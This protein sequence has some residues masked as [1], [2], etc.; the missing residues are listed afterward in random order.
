MALSSE[1]R[2]LFNQVVLIITSGSLNGMRHV[3]EHA[4]EALLGRGEDC[5]VRL[6][7]SRG[8]E[9]VSRHHCRLVLAPPEATLQDLGSKNG[10]LLNGVELRGRPRPTPLQDGD[11]ISVGRTT[12]RVE[13]WRSLARTFDTLT[14]DGQGSTPSLGMPALPGSMA[15]VELS[16][17]LIDKPLGRGVAGEVFLAQ[18]QASGRLVAIKTLHEQ[19][20][21]ALGLRSFVREIENLTALKHRHIVQLLAVGLRGQSP[22]LVLEY[23]NRGSL[24]SYSA[25]CGGYVPLGEAVRYLIQV[26]DGLEFAHS[27]QTESHGSG[28]RVVQS[29]GFVHRDLK[30]GNILLHEENGALIAKI[31]DFGLGK[32]AGAEGFTATGSVSGTPTYMPRQ[33]VLDYKYAQPE[34]DVWAATACFFR[35]VT[36]AYPKPLS[37]GTDPWMTA[38]TV[39][40]T[41]IRELRD[42]VPPPLAEVIDEALV[43]TP[44]IRI[45][46]AAELKRRLFDALRRIKSGEG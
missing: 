46:T 1:Q 33:Q 3:F 19:A 6:P 14:G 44:G 27:Q 25:E 38:L 4:A 26:L 23:C 12:L 37:H 28:G 9:G 15:L 17:Y 34:V 42:N 2:T 36:G 18:E 31:A 8:Y 24:D 35:I 30:P 13:I 20:G 10:T 39:R 32:A 21:S 41:P 11:V 7:E 29:Q 40:A 43:D 5:G 45:K 16:D 22:F